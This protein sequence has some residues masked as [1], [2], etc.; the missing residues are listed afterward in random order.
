[1][2]D[3]SLA[4]AQQPPESDLV[5][6]RQTM[7]RNELMLSAKTQTMIN[8]LKSL[9]RHFYSVGKYKAADGTWQDKMEPDAF[10]VQ[11][12]ATLQAVNTEVLSMTWENPDDL[13]NAA[14]TVRVRGWKGPKET[15]TIEKTVELRLSM[16][17]IAAKYVMDKLE[18]KKRW[19]DSTRRKEEMPAEW[20]EDDVV[21]RDDGWVQPKGVKH[22][23]A[24]RSF[25]IDQYSFLGRTAESKAERRVNLKLL[26]FDWRDPDEITDESGEVAA[27]Q[28]GQ[29]P[30]Y[31]DPG[32]VLAAIDQCKTEAEITALTPTLTVE[33][34]RLSE[35]DRQKV[36]QRLKERRDAVSKDPAVASK[37]E[38]VAST[39]TAVSPESDEPAKTA[40]MPED[41][42]QGWL[43]GMRNQETAE[44]LDD[45]L[46]A[47]MGKPMS[48]QQRATLGTAY[49]KAM[50]DLKASEK[51]PAKKKS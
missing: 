26:G 46:T 50:A 13:L 49:Q 41:D 9:D 34:G 23:I 39:K 12:M 5:R 51:K 10:A 28:K 47:A 4:P 30:A 36:F 2:S 11:T 16:R 40:E 19:N 42:F 14:V 21:L 45:L 7:E 48:P 44:G 1:M 8:Q 43:E 6:V 29:Q 35:E 31:A 32:P 38:P 15:P 24:M 22:Q 20:A 37:A 3:Q 27:V 33:T 17:A 18:P 25:L